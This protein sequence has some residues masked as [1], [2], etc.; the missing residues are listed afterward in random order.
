[1]ILKHDMSST[2]MS[3]ASS[4][5]INGSLLNTDLVLPNT[6]SYIGSYAF[7]NC[8]NLENINIPNTVTSIGDGAFLNCTSLESVVIPDSV[9]SI[10]LNTF[11]GC[12]NLKSVEISNRITNISYSAFGG[13]SSLA[14]IDFEGTIEQWNAITKD[15]SWNTNTANYTIY[16]TDGE[17]AKD[18]T[19]TEY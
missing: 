3:Y 17:I 19:V 14:N 7:F 13:C 10:G 5:Y 4:L 15:A 11:H 16:C 2:P 9:T 6:V 1:M 18:G 12:S 8:N